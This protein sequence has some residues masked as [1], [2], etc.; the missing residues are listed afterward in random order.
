MEA[1][2]SAELAAQD[3]QAALRSGELAGGRELHPRMLEQLALLTHAV[4]KR[5]DRLPQAAVARCG[6]D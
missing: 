2:G 6:L 5:A 1:R 4:A 3:L